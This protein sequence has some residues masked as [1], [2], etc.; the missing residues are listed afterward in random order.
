MLDQ[1]LVSAEA[2]VDHS[3]LVSRRETAVGSGPRTREEGGG[4]VRWRD[5]GEDVI[6]DALEMSDGLCPL[7]THRGFAYVAPLLKLPFSCDCLGADIRVGPYASVELGRSWF[8]RPLADAYRAVWTGRVLDR[9]SKL[10]NGMRAVW[11]LL[12]A[13]RVN[14]IYP[15]PVQLPPA[16]SHV[17]DAAALFALLA[18]LRVAIGSEN[19]LPMPFS[20]TLVQDYCRVE[21]GAAHRQIKAL[22]E[23][24]VIVKV[25]EEPRRGGHRHGAALYRP[26]GVVV[27]IRGGER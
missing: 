2:E 13:E 24:G 16:P 8:H 22:I 7:P 4:C 1:A 10:S 5:V 11:T 19:A 9:R 21:R 25:G 20:V 23:A 26:G 14:L 6:A 12:L 17:V 27:P 15:A 18:G 3:S